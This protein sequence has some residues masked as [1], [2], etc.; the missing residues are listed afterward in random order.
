MRTLVIGGSGYLG[1]LLM[2]YLRKESWARVL[3]VVEPREVCDEFAMGSACEVADLERA[4]VGIDGVLYLPYGD[5]SD[6][7][8]VLS[9]YDLSLKA[10]HLALEVARRARIP[11]FVYASTLSIYQSFTTHFLT[12]EEE[13]P[14]NATEIYG[15]TK[16]LGELVCRFFGDNHGMTVT[17][18]RLCFPVPEDKWQQMVQ[19]GGYTLATSAPDVADAMLRSL[20]RQ[21]PGYVALFTTGDYEERQMSQRRAWEVLGWA[22]QARPRCKAE[23]C[24]AV[25]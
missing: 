5:G 9:S 12:S 10:V 13:C 1:T 24:C 7:E 6:Y 21:S 8:R 3:D 20:R 19:K 4:A 16:W 17:A 23:E 25:V 2:P 11:H 22:P 18:L 15:F 14:G